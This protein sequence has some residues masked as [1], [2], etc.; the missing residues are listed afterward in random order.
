MEISVFI[1]SR[2]GR[3]DRELI[4]KAVRTALFRCKLR[5]LTPTSIPELQA[6]VLEEAKT[7]DALMICGGDGTLNAALQPLLSARETFERFPTICPLPVGTANDFAQELG[8]GH[9]IERAARLVLE[10]EIQDVDVLQVTSG[11]NE[12][13]M[14]TNGGLG[15]P[16]ETADLVNRFRKWLV[17]TSE[18]DDVKAHWRPVL[19]LGK[20]AVKKAGSRIY[21][22]TLAGKLTQWSINDWK[23]E[24]EIPGQTILTTHAPFIMINNQKVLGANYQ[25]A[26]LTAN[27]DGTFNIMLVTALTLADQAKTL[28]KIRKGEIPSEMDCPR[29]EAS[30]CTIRRRGVRPLTFFGDGE[31]LHR[32]VEEVHVRC[33]HRALPVFVRGAA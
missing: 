5:F 33:L 8:I 13:F 21:E 27:N 22:L 25:A 7:A 28:M 29:F 17:E 1:N 6:N 14:L 9:R 2:A 16:A 24:V 32:E 11:N 23:V 18:C 10:G 30:E 31:I 4:E 3:A 12:A 19:Q 15:V 26:P 20:H